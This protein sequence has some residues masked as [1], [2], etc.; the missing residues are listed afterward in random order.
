MQLLMIE[1]EQIAANVKQR[2]NEAYR[3]LEESIWDVNKGCSA[4][5][6]E[7]YRLTISKIFSVIVFDLMEPLYQRHPQLK[8]EDWQD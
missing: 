8:P 7:A 2:L 6:A 5:E 4:E 1:N 3:I